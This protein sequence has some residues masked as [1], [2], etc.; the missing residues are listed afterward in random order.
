MRMFDILCAKSGSFSRAD[1]PNA[2][3][4]ARLTIL[5]LML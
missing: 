5:W 2:G 4:N 3:E 1:K